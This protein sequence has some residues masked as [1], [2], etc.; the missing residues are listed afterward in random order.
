MGAGYQELEQS[1]EEVLASIDDTGGFPPTLTLYQQGE[2]ALGFYHQRAD[3]RAARP[4]ARQ[5][6]PAQATLPK[7]QT[8]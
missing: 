8:T 4:F 5:A 7:E 3:F 6:P 2:F 1:L